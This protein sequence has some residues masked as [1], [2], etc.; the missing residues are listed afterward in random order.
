[1]EGKE[2]ASMY[3]DRFDTLGCSGKAG[4]GLNTLQYSACDSVGNV[5]IQHASAFTTYG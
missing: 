5:T 2:G 3:P 4:P 1:M